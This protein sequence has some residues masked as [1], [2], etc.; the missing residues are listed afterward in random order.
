MFARDAAREEFRIAPELRRL[1][2][3]AQ[4]NLM[5]ERYER[6]E[7]FD[8][9]FCRNVLIYF[10]KDDADGVI[11]RLLGHLRVGGYLMLG[12]SETMTAQGSRTPATDR[13]E[14][15]REGAIGDAPQTRSA[16]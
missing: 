9:I 12:H 7:V 10:A 8:V 15:V 6:D 5:D 4:L 1:V 3:F 2:S 16:C 14:R 13:S 11:E